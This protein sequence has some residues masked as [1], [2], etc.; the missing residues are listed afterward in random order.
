MISGFTL[1]FSRSHDFAEMDDDDSPILRLLPG[2]LRNGG[3]IKKARQLLAGG[4]VKLLSLDIFD[5]ILLRNWSS[6]LERFAGAAALMHRKFPRISQEEFYEA[7][8]LAHQMAYRSVPLVDG[9]REASAERIFSIMARILNMS[10]SEIPV[11]MEE[12][13]EYETGRLRVNPV[14]R[15]LLKDALVLNIAVIAV[16]DMYWSG[17]VLA[18]LL[19]KLLPEAEAIRHVYS[20]SDFG[21]SKESGLLFDRVIHETGCF[22]KDVLHLGDNHRADFLIPRARNG[23]RSIW[24]PRSALYCRFC[25]LRQRYDKRI[26]HERNILHGL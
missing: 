9:C 24:L 16:S 12:E 10:P 3:R 4:M 6:E 1:W 20:S 19:N 11:M 21:V 5:T 7:R 8:A 25:E 23:I 17:K 13:L 15:T 26:L 2:C 14:V 22:P 18:G